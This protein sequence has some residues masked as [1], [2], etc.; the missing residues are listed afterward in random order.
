MTLIIQAEC[1]FNCCNHIVIKGNVTLVS[2]GGGA[3]QLDSTAKSAAA[4]GDDH[5]IS[6]NEHHKKGRK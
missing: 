2:G 5:L 4:L 1:I 3:D 6:V